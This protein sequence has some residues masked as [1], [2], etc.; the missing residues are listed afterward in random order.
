[1]RLGYIPA[2]RSTTRSTGLYINVAAGN[3][4][5]T[6]LK[7]AEGSSPVTAAFIMLD[8]RRDLVNR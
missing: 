4:V 7:A 8:R 5:N 6:F 1:M 3:H 2:G